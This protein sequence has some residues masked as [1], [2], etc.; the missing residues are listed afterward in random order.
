M[1]CPGRSSAP[2]LHITNGKIEQ[3]KDSYGCNDSP[4]KQGN[5][6]IYMEC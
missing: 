5:K 2:H 1:L 4:E 3:R 6:K